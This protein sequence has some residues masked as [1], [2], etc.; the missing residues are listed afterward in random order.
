MNRC[1]PIHPAGKLWAAACLLCCALVSACSSSEQ[2]AVDQGR[3]LFQSKALS[4]SHLND[5]TCLTCHDTVASTPPSQKAGGALAGVTLRST[6]WGG[7]VADLLSSIDACRNNFM[8]DTRP[9]SANSEQARALYAY[10]ASLEPGDADAIPFTIVTTIDPL[11]RGETAEAISS[12]V[13]H[14]QVLYATTCLYC[15]G[16]MHDGLGRL[17]ERVPILPEDTLVE[18]AQ[19]SAR[20]QRLIFTEKIRHGLFLGYGGEMPPFSAEL[21]SDQ[22]VSDLLEA[23]NVLG[24]VLDE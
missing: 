10:L 8:G 12:A 22:D 13:S 20:E 3:E 6:F 4:Q 9:L 7:Q 19:Y 2:S 5:Y 15:H 21:L 14:G 16:S 23:L 24:S 1:H 11:P 18:H 17:S